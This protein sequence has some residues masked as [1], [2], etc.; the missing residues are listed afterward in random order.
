MRSRIAREGSVGLLILA[1]AGIFVASIAW[2]KGMNPANRSF[3]ILVN[4]PT[5]AGVQSGSSVRYR[6]VTVGRI[7]SIKPSSQGVEVKISVAPA[8]LVIP[9]DAVA[10]IDQS[11]LLGENVLNLTPKNDTVP[12]VS[13][14]PLDANCDKNLILCDGSQIGG[15]LGISTDAL[16]RSSIRFADLYGQPEFYAN[17]NQLTANSGKAAAE[18]A[19]MSREF[20][21]L[22]RSFRQ[23]LGTLSG[24]AVSIS[25]AAVQTGAAASQA[26]ITA[27][28]AG[29]TLDQ[30]NG[31]LV[32]NRGTLVA[33]LDNINQ[34]SDTLKVSVDR[35]PATI[36][37]FQRSRVLND[38]EA[39]SANA[40]VASKNLKDASQAFSNPA[41]ITSLQQTLDAARST[42]Q[43][44]QKITT[45][46]DELT[47]D[48]ELRKQFKDVIKGF[49]QLLSSSEEVQQRAIYAQQLE[50][51]AQQM[52]IERDLAVRQLAQHQRVIEP[53]LTP[54][55]AAPV[56]APA[57]PPVTPPQP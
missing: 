40:A 15:D 18:I 38:L 52:A 26:G 6:G 50:P 8:D 13:A 27:N 47:G 45:D 24:T 39:L 28:K 57:A 36:D 49:G 20:G 55:L 1:G 48:P 23:E 19:T 2:L 3:N 56:A 53:Q 14:K 25:G 35:L 22:A 42:F 41:T 31:L 44:I 33:T 51:A 10:T 7:S 43:N 29:V 16:V 9:A 12:Q 17:L 21:I 34:T 30:I 54:Q 37:R 32:E 4:F 46:V 11:G 5:I